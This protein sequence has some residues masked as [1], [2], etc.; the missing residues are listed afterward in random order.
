M[1]VFQSYNF[2]ESRC[3]CI[4]N[5]NMSVLPRSALKQQYELFLGKLRYSVLTLVLEVT[6]LM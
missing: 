4:Y 5:Y 6:G 2:V 1:H 3:F